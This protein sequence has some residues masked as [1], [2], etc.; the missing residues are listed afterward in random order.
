MKE[1]TQD[2]FIDYIEKHHPEKLKD[3]PKIVEIVGNIVVFELE[4]YE[5]KFCLC[6]QS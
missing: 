2:V 6:I 3:K 4:D 5:G 1:I